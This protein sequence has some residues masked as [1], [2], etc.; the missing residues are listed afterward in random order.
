MSR[1][2]RVS[3]DLD[4]HDE[5]SPI[6]SSDL[7]HDPWLTCAG[8]NLS[9]LAAELFEKCETMHQVHGNRKPRRDATERR[10][11]LVDNLVANLAE[12]ILRY[13]SNT[14][15]AIPTKRQARTRYDR[16]DLP[17]HLVSAALVNLEHLG[18]IH[19]HQGVRNQTRTSFEP[20][21]RLRARVVA[22][23]GLQEVAWSGEGETIILHASGQDRGASKPLV[24]YVDTKVT[25]RLR[26][27]M[28]AI[29]EHLNTASITVDDVPTGAIHL[30]RR[31]QIPR[32]DAPHTFDQHGRLY[33]GFWINMHRTE[34]HRI[35]IDGEELADLDFTA[36][37]TQLA[38]LHA[39]LP[40]PQGD[41]YGGIEGM[42]GTDA[43]AELQA[44]QRDAVKRGLNAFFFRTGRMMRLPPAVKRLLETDWNATR[45][46][47]AMRKRHAPI[48]HLFG[49]GLGLSFMFTESQIMVRCLLNLEATGVVA[50]PIHDGLL[51][52]RSCVHLALAAMREASRVVTGVELPVKVK[53]LV[54]RE[55]I[56]SSSP[57]HT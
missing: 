15:I 6:E 56:S 12:L 38:Y 11:M 53:S 14:G 50:L 9:A 4:L 35:R 52:R 39:G 3:G 49:T 19:L 36:M 25:H 5:L 23:V 44:R 28:A 27:E 10:R 1:T 17:P 48:K 2:E 51:V 57:A 42:A 13:S 18:F 8:E 55:A 37:F 46:A 40:L 43:P 29:N 16:P 24:D 47:A 7:M 54:G 34:R 33:G 32:L 41:P 45:F 30:T 31:F 26:L 22:E 20:T 21:T